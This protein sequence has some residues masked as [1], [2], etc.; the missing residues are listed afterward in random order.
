MIHRYEQWLEE[1]EL[2]DA[3]PAPTDVT[4][5]TSA[6]TAAPAPAPAPMPAPAPVPSDVETTPSE[7]TGTAETEI[8]Q[9]RELDKKR[10][11]A[12]KAFKKKQREFLEIPD[13]VRKNPVEEADKTKVEELKKEIIELNKTMRD[14]QRDWDE[15]NAKTLGIEDDLEMDEEP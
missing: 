8:D 5:P 12:I 15:F 1:S 13:D 7:E 2:M 11:D 4:S 3:N 10:R 9:F 6:P 14:A